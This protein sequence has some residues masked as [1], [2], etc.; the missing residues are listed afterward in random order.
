[1]KIKAYTIENLGGGTMAY[2]GEFTNGKFFSGNEDA[3]NL[4]EKSD[5]HF[6]MGDVEY[7]EEE[8]QEFYK[9]NMIEQ[10]EPFTEFFKEITNEINF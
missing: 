6:Y 10:F 9:Q 4:L 2:F 7:T 5:K 3:L 8:M 1:M